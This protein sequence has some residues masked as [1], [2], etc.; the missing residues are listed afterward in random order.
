MPAECKLDAVIPP[1][2]STY[3]KLQLNLDVTLELGYHTHLNVS[4]ETA[5][6]KSKK[7]LL[8]TVS[9]PSDVICCY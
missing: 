6:S 7:W 4:S 5:V 1:C 2:R 3:R 8:S 9:V